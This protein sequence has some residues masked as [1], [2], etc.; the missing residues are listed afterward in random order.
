[1]A[2]KGPDTLEKLGA[3]LDA[4]KARAGMDTDGESRES[5]A[6]PAQDMGKAMRMGIE[7]V[8]GVAVGAVAGFFLDRWLGTMPLFFILLF[9]LGAAAGFRNMLR[10]AGVLGKKTKL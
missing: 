9:F 4:A 6:P 7:L 2:E 1:M 8:A 3:E 5:S 10:D